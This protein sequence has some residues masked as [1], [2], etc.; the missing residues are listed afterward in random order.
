MKCAFLKKGFGGDSFLD[1]FFFI[2][3]S[4]AGVNRPDPEV[5]EPDPDVM[6]QIP[7]LPLLVL[8]LCFPESTTGGFPVASKPNLVGIFNFGDGDGE[9]FL[10][11][12][13]LTDLGDEL[14]RGLW[15][16][17]SSEVSDWEE[18]VMTR[19]FFRA[20]EVESCDP[21]RSSLSNLAESTESSLM[22]ERRLPRMKVSHSAESVGGVPCT[23]DCEAEWTPGLDAGSL[24][25]FRSLR[26]L[27]PS[28]S[29]G[30]VPYTLSV[31]ERDA[32][33]S[34]MGLPD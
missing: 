19:G 5:V 28:G 12:L 22:L 6:D 21:L 10:A 4:A 18:Q 33:G 17:S 23:L 34:G 14:G 7:E 11:F 20:E 29:L 9:R 27:K 1:F 2:R 3:S 15:A 26:S 24:S 31:E 30:G 8:S 32:R 25:S 13:E 16:A